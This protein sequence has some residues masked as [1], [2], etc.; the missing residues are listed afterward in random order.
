MSSREQHHGR[1][2]SAR[3]GRNF[4]TGIFLFSATAA[5]VLWQN[6]HLTVLWD[7]SYILENSTRISLGQLP[8]R[9]FPFP[10]APLTFLVQ[11]AIIK[12][13]GRAVLHHYLYSAIAAACATLATWRILLRLLAASRL[14]VRLSAFLLALPLVFLGTASIFPHPFYDS[15]CTLL[16]LLCCWLLLW[17][18]S[19]NFPAIPTFACGVLLAIPP[20][21][22]QN[23]GLAFLLSSVLLL[24]YLGFRE[25]LRA[26]PVAENGTASLPS[27]G[28]LL[29]AGAATGF[30]AALA[31]IHF[32]V[33]LANYYH[34]TIQFAAAR[35]LPDFATMLGVYSG[36]ALIW[37][38][39]VFAAG[40]VLFRFR[41]PAVRWSAAALVSLPFLAAGA[42]LFTQQY[43]SDRVEALLHLWPVLLAASLVFACWSL[44]RA[45]SIA[46]ILPLI[47]L[48]A[49]HGAFLS[50]QLWGSTYALW[51]LLMILLASILVAIAP[52]VQK[53]SPAAG[54]FDPSAAVSTA[55]NSQP[56]SELPLVAFTA[57]AALVLLI[58]GGYYS[59]SHERLAYVDLDGE[60]LTHSSLPALRGLAMRGT[61]LPDFAELVAY[62]DR[63]IPRA[64]AILAIPGE[65]LFYFTTGRTPQFPVVMMDNTV[66]PYSAAELVQL[67]R[68]HNVQ[69]LIVKRTLQLQEEPIAFR[70]QL[71]QLLSQDFTQ[72]ESLNNYDIYRRNR[73]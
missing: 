63:N 3:F 18:E 13:F 66:N 5:F 64:D 27:A 1:P 67:A 35:R 21:C 70:P 29:L 58:T 2:A 69:W 72:V 73:N 60:T 30:A 25:R 26:T 4:L 37:L 49:I 44:A 71:L 62:T 7:L 46:Q 16:I 8:Y 19:R 53:T 17:L 34:W 24:A 57:L 6:L 22:K 20:F 23:T 65:D 36:S 11:A 47:L 10:Y 50:Q 56:A 15:D 38:Y 39:V 54:A 9:D 43:A 33:G 14:P 31:I 41:R 40:L 68:E 55:S 59:L 61:Y 32:T 52:A 48:A 12:L 51:P 42:A 45:R 28:A